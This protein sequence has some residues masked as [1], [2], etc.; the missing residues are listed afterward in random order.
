MKLNIKSSAALLTGFLML[1]QGCTDNFEDINTDPTTLT[2]SNFD[3]NTLLPSVMLSYLGDASSNVYIAS[4]FVQLMANCATSVDLKMT[5]GDKY[6]D[7]DGNHWMHDVFGSGYGD[8][9][10]SLVELQAL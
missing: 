4:N 9:I 1:S 2:E 3:P 6:M 7:N 10:K 5:T 8:H